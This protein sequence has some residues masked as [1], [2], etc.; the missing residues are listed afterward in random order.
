MTAPDVRAAALADIARLRQ[1]AEAIGHDGEA[2]APHGL[3]VRVRLLD[4]LLVGMVDQL[5]T[6]IAAHAC[7]AV[8][9]GTA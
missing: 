3:A 8:V 5:T 2:D 4:D 6:R 9:W 7:A 1:F